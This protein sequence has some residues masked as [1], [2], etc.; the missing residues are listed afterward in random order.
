MLAD[1]AVA[2]EA[3]ADEVADVDWADAPDEAV[4]ADGDAEDWLAALLEEAVHL[5]YHWPPL[6]L[7]PKPHQ[8]IIMGWVAAPYRFDRNYSQGVG[9]VSVCA[10]KSPSMPLFICASMAGK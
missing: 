4:D 10:W 2:P 1:E 6:C 9:R 3:V 7:P 5:F 8:R